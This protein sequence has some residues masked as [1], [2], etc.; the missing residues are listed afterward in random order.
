MR[1]IDWALPY[2]I[3]QKEDNLLIKWKNNKNENE[4]FEEGLNF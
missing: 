2:E 4:T 1:V 3:N